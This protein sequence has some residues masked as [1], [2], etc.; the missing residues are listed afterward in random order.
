MW[1]NPVAFAIPASRTWGNLGRG[2]ARGPGA[3]QVDWALQKVNHI[4]EKKTITL[5]FEAFNLFNFTQAANPGSTWTSPASFGIVS[6]G[7]NRTIGSGTSRQ[8]QL[9]MRLNF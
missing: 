2:V 9:A 1:Y 4:T 5:R 7:L 8:L 6:S 3:G